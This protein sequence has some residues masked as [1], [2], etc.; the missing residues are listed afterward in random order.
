MKLVFAVV[1]VAV[2][3]RAAAADPMYS[4]H[5]VPADTKLYAEFKNPSSLA[6]LATW[7]LG[8][9]CKNIIFTPEVAQHATRVH[10][11]A[12]NEMTPKQALQLFIDAVDATGLV[13]TDKG[14]TIVI[15]PGPN[16]P[17]SC[18]DVTA[19]AAVAPATTPTTG[20][21]RRSPPRSPTPTSTPASW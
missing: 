15:K 1:A 12:P 13:V 8:F 18:P 9:S 6:D 4:C 19:A 11:V 14:D 20:V 2:L 3:G 17:A 16:M 21:T 5:A 10:I 7:V